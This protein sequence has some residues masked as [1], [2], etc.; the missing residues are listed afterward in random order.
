ML[1]KKTEILLNRLLAKKASR[2]KE[3]AFRRKLKTD[4]QVE[5]ILKENQGK[6]VDFMSTFAT[7]F[8]LGAFGDKQYVQVKRKDPNT[9]KLE[10]IQ[11][12]LDEVKSDDIVLPGTIGIQ[13]VKS[14]NLVRVYYGPSYINFEGFVKAKIEKLY[15]LEEILISASKALT[16]KS[17]IEKLNPENTSEIKIE[18]PKVIVP[19][20]LQKKEIKA[21]GIEKEYSDWLAA[22]HDLEKYLSDDKAM[23]KINSKS[24]SNF[25]DLDLKAIHEKKFIKSK[26]NPNKL[27]LRYNNAYYIDVDQYKANKDLY[28]LATEPLLGPGNVVELEKDGPEKG[29][30]KPNVFTLVKSG[31]KFFYYNTD[32]SALTEIK[33]ADELA[34][35]SSKHSSVGDGVIHTYYPTVRKK[36]EFKGTS[37]FKSVLQQAKRFKVET[38]ENVLLHFYQ[39]TDAYAIEAAAAD[40]LREEA[41]AEYAIQKR[42]KALEAQRKLESAVE[43]SKW[44][45]EGVNNN[46][47]QQKE[48]ISKEFERFLNIKTTQKQ[49]IIADLEHKN[50]TSYYL[51]KAIGFKELSEIA[52]LDI[53][54]RV[55]VNYTENGMGYGR[56]EYL[57]EIQEKINSL[58]EKYGISNIVSF[59]NWAKNQ[60][61]EKIQKL[62]IEKSSENL[63]EQE[64]LEDKFFGQFGL[65]ISPIGNQIYIDLNKA[66]ATPT[67]LKAK[68]IVKDKTS[69]LPFKLTK[70]QPLFDPKDVFEDYLALRNDPATTTEAL[71]LVSEEYHTIW[72]DKV[73][74]LKEIVNEL[75][76]ILSSKALQEFNVDGIKTKQGFLNFVFAAFDSYEAYLKI[77]E[78]KKRV[79]KGSKEAEIKYL[80]KNKNPYLYLAFFEP[81]KYVEVRLKAMKTSSEYLNLKDVFS[82]YGTD[83]IRILS[84]EDAYIEYMD[85]I[86]GKSPSNKLASNNSFVESAVKH[87][88]Y[89]FL[90]VDEQLDNIG[91]NGMSPILG[92]ENLEELTIKQDKL[93]ALQGKTNFKTKAEKTRVEA[94]IKQLEKDIKELQ[95]STKDI[96]DSTGNLTTIQLLWDSISMPRTLTGNLSVT[97][98]W[99]QMGM[100]YSDDL[101][102]PE[103]FKDFVNTTKIGM[104]QVFDNLEAQGWKMYYR[105]MTNENFKKNVATTEFLQKVLDANNNKLALDKEQLISGLAQENNKL[106]DALGKFTYVKNKSQVSPFAEKLNDPK[107][108]ELAES[109]RTS[110]LEGTS[111]SK[112]RN[113]IVVK[114][115]QKDLEASGIRTTSLAEDLGLVKPSETFTY[116]DGTTFTAEA[117][118]ENLSVIADKILKGMTE[119]IFTQKQIMAEVRTHYYT[120]SDEIQTEEGDSMSHVDLTIAQ[121]YSEERISGLNIKTDLFHIAKQLGE[122]TDI[123]KELIELFRANR[124]FSKKMRLSNVVPK[125]LGHE[126][127]SKQ[128]GIIQFGAQVL[129]SLG[130]YWEQGTSHTGTG[131]FMFEYD[132]ESK[133][134]FTNLSSQGFVDLKNAVLY[135]IA[136]SE[137]LKNLLYEDSISGNSVGLQDKIDYVKSKLENVQDADLL[138]ESNQ[139]NFSFTKSTVEQKVAFALIHL[140]TQTGEINFSYDLTPADL[141]L[142]FV[143]RVDSKFV[144]EK[145]KIGSDTSSIPALVAQF[146]TALTVKEI[147]VV[148]DFLKDKL[149][150]KTY[151]NKTL[152][153]DQLTSILTG[154]SDAHSLYEN[155][156]NTIK[157]TNPEYLLKKNLDAVDLDNEALKDIGINNYFNL[158]TKLFNNFGLL[159]LELNKIAYARAQDIVK[160]ELLALLKKNK[161]SIGITEDLAFFT[162]NEKDKNRIEF[163][164]PENIDIVTY[165]ILGKSYALVLFMDMLEKKKK[166]LLEK[167][168]DFLEKRPSWMN[169]FGLGTGVSSTSVAPVIVSLYTRFFNGI[170][171]HLDKHFEISQDAK[172]VFKEP[173]SKYNFRY[174]EKEETKEEKLQVQ[175]TIF[176]EKI[177]KYTQGMAPVMGTQPSVYI[178]RGI[179]I[180]TQGLPFDQMLKSKIENQETSSSFLEN[181]I[182]DGNRITKRGLLWITKATK[183]QTNESIANTFVRAEEKRKETTKSIKDTTEKIKTLKAKVNAIISLNKPVSRFS[184]EKNNVSVI[185]GII[186]ATLEKIGYTVTSEKDAYIVNYR[187]KTNMSPKKRIK[188]IGKIELHLVDLA[189]HLPYVSHK[190]EEYKKTMG[191]SVLNS[192]QEFKLDTYNLKLPKDIIEAN[193]VSFNSL[194]NDLLKIFSRIEKAEENAFNKDVKTA[195]GD[196]IYA[197]IDSYR[198]ELE[199][200]KSKAISATPEK[201]AELKQQIKNGANEIINMIRENLRSGEQIEGLDSTQILE[202]QEEIIKLEG[203]LNLLNLE[204]TSGVYEITPEEKAGILAFYNQSRDILGNLA[205]DL[206]FK[207]DLIDEPVQKQMVAEFLGELS[208]GNL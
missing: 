155:F 181:D 203:N 65:T 182:F 36:R 7:H 141:N 75:K 125:L 204:N 159:S 102:S 86:R 170:E 101:T 197:K 173:A 4:E 32:P 73:A 91:I 121:S 46:L 30:E 3:S 71:T 104:L 134:D 40:K 191:S 146:N 163:N 195:L 92:K 128:I 95:S 57:P 69:K 51:G 118:S 24:W 85:E 151:T 82:F 164:L 54:S 14:Q 168:K 60:R 103:N 185:I 64:K 21:L 122:N 66:I 120:V 13:E 94:E 188:E 8:L 87:L 177:V 129:A 33:D 206:L 26:F 70:D 205:K 201:K 18:P 12:S 52:D 89:K 6:P 23:D 20:L 84:V 196:K 126:V 79:Y 153:A 5:E 132:P 29:R 157:G 35:L 135:T 61:F 81:V 108:Y 1:N 178:K 158:S 97:S 145:K 176:D 83:K 154:A 162:T 193:V 123:P 186:K 198:D 166:G 138:G 34:E 136:K 56:H 93:T 171:K 140:F 194:L 48:K 15:N 207:I 175:K 2:V 74:E 37:N 78:Y 76:P 22:S 72:K 49:Q 114:L 27:N 47:K 16:T 189:D 116:E 115:K 192:L 62:E 150:K 77:K 187:L 90:K 39:Q 19:R 105:Y 179:N 59:V 38:F 142:V 100:R 127:Y 172:R 148:I 44:F 25:Y 10:T 149:F 109:V 88:V 106:I 119:E 144:E 200:I 137:E 117:S 113:L 112:L 165:T 68:N 31:E 174:D 202:Y 11:V 183:N 17:N 67:I 63:R 58:V 45:L 180:L 80:E 98:P 131:Q 208:E 43:S 152:T 133:M 42:D 55:V 139:F 130:F 199:Q 184:T 147:K 161:E 160:K 167:V 110:I 96:S 143:K 111:V 99:A 124:V 156:L 28:T 169:L 9:K 50:P 107:V 190:L 41:A 53:Y